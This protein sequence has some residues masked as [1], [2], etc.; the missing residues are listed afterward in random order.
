MKSISFIIFLLA[1][2][3]VFAKDTSNIIPSRESREVKMAESAIFF[4]LMIPTNKQRSE[5]ADE[6]GDLG[7]TLIGARSS[8]TSLISLASLL[9]FQLDAGLGEDYDCYVAEKGKRFLPYLK[10][11]N[12]EKLEAHCLGEVQKIIF[13]D[14][15]A[16]GEESKAECRTK[17]E[18][19][20]KVKE[21]ISSI[22]TR[23]NPEDF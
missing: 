10:R 22:N 4:S 8:K 16:Y 11:I 3:C 18:I 13:H 21:L 6:I 5:D 15:T 14:P 20:E 9:R 1:T 23:C 19:K 7:L 17:V 12:P 2:Q